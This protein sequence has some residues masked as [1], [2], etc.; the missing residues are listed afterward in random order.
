MENLALNGVNDILLSVDAFHQESIP[1]GPV[2]SFA[3][4]VKAVGI[5]LRTHP[6]WLVNP[7]DK[8][9]YNLKT[10]EILKEFSALGITPSQ[11]N[12][13][14]PSGN[15]LKYLGEYFDHGEE[16]INPYKEDPKD[17]RALCVSPGGDLLEGN[18]YQTNI[19][20]ILENY[21][22]GNQPFL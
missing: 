9:P 8:N 1:L 6:A 22:P 19:L 12:L 17:L 15:A 2:K 10:L 20:S 4:A 16:Y 11:G 3:K 13:I 14:F 18:I 21:S 7:K 5:P